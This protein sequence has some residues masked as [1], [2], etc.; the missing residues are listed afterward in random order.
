MAIVNVRYLDIV[1]SPS[2]SAA[3]SWRGGLALG[4]LRALLGGQGNIGVKSGGALAGQP[5]MRLSFTRASLDQAHLGLGW[6]S[7][8]E[9]LMPPCKP[10]L[11]VA[12][13]GH[14][15]QPGRTR[16][17]WSTLSLTL[18]GL[19][20]MKLSETKGD[21]RCSYGLP[22]CSDEEVICDRGPRRVALG[23]SA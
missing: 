1:N 17:E 18:G 11:L 12:R 22:Q 21:L 23:A 8:P 3:L 13:I 10:S 15:R 19:D 4:L 20:A 7:N 9:K 14:Q 2:R 16:T 5:P 6:K